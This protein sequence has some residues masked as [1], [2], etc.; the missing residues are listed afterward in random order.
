MSLVNTV[1][2]GVFAAVLGPMEGLPAIVPLSILA[3]LSAMGM[4]VVFK[5]TSDQE[6]IARVKDRI[7]ACIFEIRLFN[8]DMG[9]ILRAQRN[10]LEYNLQYAA[11]SLV[12]AIWLIVPFVLVI[13]QLQA[14]YGWDG[15]EPGTPR[16]LQAELVQSWVHESGFDDFSTGRKPQV[17]LIAPAGIRVQTRPVW[18]PSTGELT[19]RVVGETPGIYDLELRVGGESVTKRVYVG[20]IEGARSPRRQQPQFVHQLLYP[21]EPPYPD[22]GIVHAVA[23]DYPDR[24]IDVFGWGIHWLILYFGLSMIFAFALRN[25]FG[26]TI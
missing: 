11:L 2:N 21:A 3:L 25:R 23:I 6:R 4:L 15:I 22:E 13:A 10:I 18:V 1:F 9:A 24:A 19:W 14:H 12:P 8:D 17:E 26:V 5:K 7:F 16:L 20:A